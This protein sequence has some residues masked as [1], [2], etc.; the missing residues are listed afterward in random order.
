MSEKKLFLSQLRVLALAGGTGLIVTAGC[1]AAMA[2]L[3]ASRDYSGA[4]AA[5]LATAAVGLGSLCSGWVAAFC[6]KERGLLCG[7]V[8]GLLYDAL[9]V[10]LSM[11]SGTI[12]E[13]ASLMRL[14]IVVL[15]G[16]VGGFLGMAGRERKHR[17]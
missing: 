8:Q 7:L 17:R 10:V 16:S 2:A 14:A 15:C 3:M 12:A 9:L 5:P 13:N 4:A 11:P 6:K 1:L